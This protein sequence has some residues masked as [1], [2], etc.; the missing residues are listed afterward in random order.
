MPWQWIGLALF[1]LTLLP[2]GSAMLA[3]R[4][5]RTWRGRL[6]PVRPRGAALLLI[7]A[8]APVNAIP[9]LTGAAPDT[10][11]MCTAVGGA[12]AVGGCLVLGFAT[13]WPR[14]SPRRSERG[15]V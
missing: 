15:H 4:V 11:L 3:D 2:A 10:A 5:P 12:L 1:T 9:R 14:R 6:A 8:A 7:Y 13:H